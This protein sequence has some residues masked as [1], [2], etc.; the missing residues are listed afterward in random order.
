MN[1]SILGL[2]L[3]GGSLGLALRE[4]GLARVTGYARRESTRRAAVRGR[5]VDVCH[6]TPADAVRD[7]D[8][9]VFCTPVLTI[10]AL[11]RECRD[12]FRPGCVVT[13]V[14]STKANVQEKAEEA[15]V[16]SRAVFVGSHPMAGSEKS[17]LEAAR[18]DLYD[19][20]VTAVTQ[21]AG[22]DGAAVDRICRLWWGVG[23]RVVRLAAAEHDALVARTSH[24]PHLL[25]ALLV[26]VAGRD[27]TDEVKAFCGAGFRDA[28]RIAAGSPD[29]WHDI[30]KTNHAALIEELRVFG[31][32]LDAL[33]SML[34]QRDYDR[35]KALLEHGRALRG[36]LVG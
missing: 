28:T 3:M 19:G 26:K 16:G 6:A 7:A 22:A 23:A 11:I 33:A 17:G 30:V 31:K 29:M 1:V 8:V 18:A 14:G 9:A 20:A 35:V 4:R 25:A 34:E 10:P 32:E 12:A 24:L 21:G 15:L 27:R 5:I 13:D 2:G 36:T